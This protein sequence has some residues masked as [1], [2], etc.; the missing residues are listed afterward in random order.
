MASGRSL[1]VAADNIVV[2]LAAETGR[3]VGRVRTAVSWFA[4]APD[5]RALAHRD[6]KEVRLWDVATGVDRFALALPAEPAAVAFT[7]DGR[8]LV[9]ADDGAA[10]WDLRR[11]VR[12]LAP[13]DSNEHWARF[14]A[15][16]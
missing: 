15:R 11:H 8:A 3:E 9:V 10:V 2:L 4:L 16:P 1:A 12:P 6:G 13:A 7:P 5:G 14:D